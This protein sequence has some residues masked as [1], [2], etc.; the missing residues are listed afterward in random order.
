MSTSKQRLHHQI[1]RENK[2]KSVNRDRRT[3]QR[4]ERMKGISPNV[5]GCLSAKRTPIGCGPIYFRMTF[6]ELQIDGGEAEPLARKTRS[7]L[8][9]GG[10]GLRS[11]L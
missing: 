10:F 11:M 9:M 5:V 7:G 3:G 6:A 1:R 8:E 2:T 4:I